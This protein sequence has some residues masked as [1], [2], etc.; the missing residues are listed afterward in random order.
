MTITNREEFVHAFDADLDKALRTGEVEALAEATSMFLSLYSATAPNGKN[1]S[2]DASNVLALFKSGLDDGLGSYDARLMRGLL[3]MLLTLNALELYVPVNQERVNVL[4][5]DN[6]TKLV[7][8][9]TG[10][11]ADRPTYSV[12]D[13]GRIGPSPEEFMDYLEIALDVHKNF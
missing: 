7:E 6:T 3:L 2:L 12:A 8:Y 4:T 10:G 11:K 9:L 1:V 13:S 5:Y